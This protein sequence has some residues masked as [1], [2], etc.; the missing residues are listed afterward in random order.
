MFQQKFKVD[1]ETAIDFIEID[2]ISGKMILYSFIYIDKDKE[3]I[4][5]HK[6]NEIKYL[7][8]YSEIKANASHIVYQCEKN[9]D[10]LN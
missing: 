3:K 2:E 9:K 5:S 1:D 8:N 4:Y 7:N 6:D 10:L